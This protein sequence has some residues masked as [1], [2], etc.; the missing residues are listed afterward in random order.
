MSA[1]TRLRPTDADKGYSVRGRILGPLELSGPLG[2]LQPNAG[3][4]RV[5]LAGLMLRADTIVPVTDL[6]TWLWDD[7][8]PATAK[9]T[10]YVYLMRLRKELA[11]G[12]GGGIRIHTAGG[13]YRL[14][15]NRDAV[16]VLVFQRLVEEALVAERRDDPKAAIDLLREA[17]ELWRGPALADVPS[18]ALR[19]DEAARLTEEWG[20]A[21]ERRIDLELGMGHPGVL[22]GELRTLTARYPSRERFWAQ[23]MIALYRDNRQVE[24]LECYRQARELLMDEFGL[25][26][27]DELRRLH[28]QILD[29]AVP[30]APLEPPRAPAAWVSQC[31]LPPDTPDFVG[32]DE[33]IDRIEDVLTAGAAAPIVLI[34]GP[35]GV[36]KSALAARVAHRM[37]H[38]FP[39]GQWY[40]RFPETKAGE[41]VEDTTLTDLLQLSG[42]DPHSVPG[43][44]LARSA[45]L[46]A[47]LTDRRVLLILDQAKNLDQVLALLPSSPGCAV[48]VT[49]TR[50][51]VG[52]PG[53]VQVSL[54]P[55]PSAQA[56]ELLEELV[57]GRV[58]EEPDAARDIA[59]LCG[60]LPL[61]LR[62]AGARLATRPG[63]RLADFAQRLG[64]TRRR[65]DELHTGSMELRASI[66]LSYVALSDG[67]RSAFR[68]LGLLD[69]SDFPEWVLAALLDR[70]DVDHLVEEFVV[71][72]LIAPVGRDRTGE[73]RYR[74]HDLLFVYAAELA[75][76]EPEHV[77]RVALRRLLDTLMQ[78]AVTAWHR[79]PR[80][81]WG[82][83]P[84][85]PPPTGALA[86][87]DERLNRLVSEPLAWDESVR[88][89]VVPLIERACEYGW[90]GDADY[91]SG[92][93]CIGTDADLERICHAVKTA[94]R[95]SGDELVWWQAELALTRRLIHQPSEEAVD[96]LTRCL[97]AFQRLS[98][99]YAVRH[100]LVWLSICYAVRGQV[101]QARQFA[102]RALAVIDDLGKDAARTLPMPDLISALATDRH[103]PEFLPK[104][105]RAWEEAERFGDLTYQWIALNGLS[106]AARNVGDL[107]WA[108]WAAE[109][110]LALADTIGEMQASAWMRVQL[111]RVRLDQGHLDEA[112]AEAERAQKIFARDLSRPGIS[113]AAELLIRI[114]SEKR[115]HAVQ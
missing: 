74:M 25:E 19:R 106:S 14:S 2:T 73:P 6:I 101:S 97:E 64:D 41:G 5:L 63:I 111:A 55:L 109:R 107:E 12:V 35:P 78:V 105:Q 27:G 76:E 10:L 66:E 20:R 40:A 56:E 81:L 7:L 32:R 54:E 28:Q 38:A 24:A 59:S 36:G 99:P 71:A 51:L 30:I 34:S 85:G 110:G 43:G 94:A 115:S 86:L 39:D 48:I 93:I 13:G 23:L 95:A 77:R 92:L 22:I 84:V 88:Q 50:L 108:L 4:H 42:V 80:I 69:G 62:I 65:L 91:L 89:L 8:P 79:H 96:R 15:L 90:H 82:R 26:P 70:E 44:Q 21:V 29:Q 57:G 53:A 113:V 17:E 98:A 49:S 37:R 18:D 68:M 102:A 114:S 100:T 33:E 87:P 61:A 52:L 103:R 3:K 16:D 83:A 67:A 112:E 9:E 47:R 58:A 72:S 31:Q 75:A 104:F 60:R 1:T 45:A 11:K 46:R